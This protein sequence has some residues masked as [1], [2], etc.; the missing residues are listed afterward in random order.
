MSTI[1]PQ[2]LVTWI[3]EYYGKAP[4][5]RVLWFY[6]RS[7]NKLYPAIRDLYEDRV[8]EF[9]YIADTYRPSVSLDQRAVLECVQFG[10][11]IFVSWIKHQ[12]Y[13]IRYT[14]ELTEATE[15]LLVA[16]DEQ[17][18]EMLPKAQSVLNDLIEWQATTALSLKMRQGSRG[19]PGM[20]GKVAD[21]VV[22]NGE[23]L[24]TVISFTLSREHA[25]AAAATAILAN[26]FGGYHP[27]ELARRLAR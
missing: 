15:N 21:T 27:E 6:C 17:L 4:G 11:R 3:E 19:A 20:R 1:T 22:E 7:F 26:R 9:N 18:N 12:G 5:S 25:L 23:L 14:Y 10:A 2:G 8:I 24:A 13:D 16:T